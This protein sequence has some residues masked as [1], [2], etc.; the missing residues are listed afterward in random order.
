M[1][2]VTYPGEKNKFSEFNSNAIFFSLLVFVFV[3]G[4]DWFDCG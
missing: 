2:T 3:V 4:K 1:D